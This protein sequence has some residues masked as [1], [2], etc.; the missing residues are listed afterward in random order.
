MVSEAEILYIET[1]KQY[2]FALNFQNCVS[3]IFG[4]KSKKLFSLKILN[5]PEM[6]E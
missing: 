3:Q 2:I 4:W 1:S 5:I 6:L